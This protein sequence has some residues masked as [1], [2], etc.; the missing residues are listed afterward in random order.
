[1]PAWSMRNHIE[2]L[3]ESVSSKKRALERGIVVPDRVMT[4]KQ[5]IENEENKLNDIKDSKP[6]LTQEEEKRVSEAYDTIVKLRSNT[7]FTYDEMNKGLADA[8]EE[9]RRLS[10]PIIKIDDSMADICETNNIHV[11][12][13][14][15]GDKYL[16]GRDADLL[17]KYTGQYLGKPT[18]MERYRKTKTTHSTER[19]RPMYMDLVE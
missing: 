5:E 10:Q 8:H 3:E 4:T 2:Q 14:S 17:A 15:K 11:S 12:A 9:A 19:V 13:N 7:M 6:K 16:S 18:N 1:M